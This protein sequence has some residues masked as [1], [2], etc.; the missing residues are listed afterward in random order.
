MYALAERT[1]FSLTS[2]TALS[3]VRY[4]F[5]EEEVLE[6]DELEVDFRR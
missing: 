4:H 1:S 5:E 2:R 3:E 6:G